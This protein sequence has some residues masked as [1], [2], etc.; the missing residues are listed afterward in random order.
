MN[1]AKI[2]LLLPNTKGGE[3]NGYEYYPNH[4]ILIRIGVKAIAFAPEGRK[5]VFCFDRLLGNPNDCPLCIRPYRR[6][7]R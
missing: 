1:R 7:V 2:I 5:T 4:F 3:R 6:I